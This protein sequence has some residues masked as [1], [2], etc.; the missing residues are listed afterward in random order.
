MSLLAI[1][2]YA[3]ETA[4]IAWTCPQTLAGGFVAD[5]IPHSQGAGCS[6]ACFEWS[7]SGRFSHEVCPFTLLA[8]SHVCYLALPVL[9]AVLSPLTGTDINVAYSETLHKL[10]SRTIARPLSHAGGARRPTSCLRAAGGPGAVLYTGCV[11]CSQSTV[12]VSIGRS[13]TRRHSLI[14]AGVSQHSVYRVHVSHFEGPSQHLAPAVNALTVHVL[15][16]Y[17]RIISG[18]FI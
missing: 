1:L 14:L 18:G 2:H 15:Y 16:R 17:V 8:R 11:L 9:H 7:R 10:A 6:S 5:A 12:S 4:D 13:W 3:C